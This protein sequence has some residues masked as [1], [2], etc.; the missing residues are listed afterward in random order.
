MNAPLDHHSTPSPGR[1]PK[2]GG[3]G[4]LMVVC[5]LDQDV[6]ES[7]RRAGL[8]DAE[9]LLDQPDWVEWRGGRAHTYAAA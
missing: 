1:K 6:V 4:W 3:H 9:R 5:C 8:P 7:L 2:S